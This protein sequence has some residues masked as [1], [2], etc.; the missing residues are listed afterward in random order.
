MSRTTIP[1]LLRTF[2]VLTA[3]ALLFGCD[4]T[5][6]SSLSPCDVSLRAIEPTQA[7]VGDQVTASGGPMTDAYDTAVY[8]G[9]ARATLSSVTRDGCDA[10]DDCLTDQACTGC[11]DC[12]SCDLLCADCLEQVAFTVPAGVAGSTVVTLFNR[13]GQSNALPF[14]VLV[15]PQDTAPQ[16]T[17]PSDTDPIDTGADD[18]GASDTAEDDTSSTETGSP[19]TATPDTGVVPDTGT[20]QGD[21]PV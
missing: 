11:D 4:S 1:S 14:E 7:M 9:T 18:T 15:P 12:D 8:V 17:G 2:T 19:D 5:S 21:P 3:G 16:D 13:H 6:T 10:C 20:A